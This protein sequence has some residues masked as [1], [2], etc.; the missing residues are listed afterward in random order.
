MKGKCVKQRKYISIYVC[1]AK[2]ENSICKKNPP[3]RICE[4]DTMD[5]RWFI[6]SIT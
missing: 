4:T 6:V 5:K 2:E 3:L 1:V